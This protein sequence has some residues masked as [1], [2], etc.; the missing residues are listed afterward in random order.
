MIDKD[1][2]SFPAE[3][4]ASE[5]MDPVQLR[6]G[7]IVICR[8]DSSRLPGKVLKR[9]RGRPLLQW[10]IDRVGQTSCFD[11][12]IVVATSDRAVDDP[13]VDY[14]NQLAIPVFRGPAND[15]AKRVLQCAQEYRLDWF[16]RI[17]GD[18]PFVDPDLLAHACN[19]ARSDRY[20]LVTNLD[21]R[22]YPYGVSVELVRTRTFAKARQVMRSAEQLEH[23]T[24]ILYESD[25]GFE[26][27]SFNVQNP[28]GDQSGYRLTVD[29]P[30]DWVRFCGLI[31]RLYGE[32]CYKLAIRLLQVKQEAA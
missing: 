17:N 5:L 27:R 26:I 20:D 3:D 21:P 10:I 12:G 24:K 11:Q 4:G 8:L 28:V 9:V 16:A 14:C 23:V 6:A 19:I 1:P 29:T 7:A 15:V 22:S 25:P 2:V 13:L 31:E 18:S 30:E 32:V